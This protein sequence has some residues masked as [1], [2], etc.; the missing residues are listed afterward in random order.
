MGTSLVSSRRR[1]KRDIYCTNTL[2]NHMAK[3]LVRRDCIHRPRV[4]IPGP[5]LKFSDFHEIFCICLFL[6]VDHF[7]VYFFSYMVILICMALVQSPPAT[8]SFCLFL[9]ALQISIFFV[10]EVF[11]HREPEG[12]FLFWPL[13]V[14]VLLS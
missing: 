14:L 10:H 9:K 3:W 13:E 7:P 12:I 5:K 1:V 11:R 2:R 6:V 4:R 8:I